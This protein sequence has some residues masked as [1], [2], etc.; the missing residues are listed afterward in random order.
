MHIE[1]IPGHPTKLGAQ[2]VWRVCE[3]IADGTRADTP[4]GCSERTL[5]ACQHHGVADALGL[6]QAQVA[7]A[8]LYYGRTDQPLTAARTTALP[9]AVHRFC[10]HVRCVY[11]DGSVLVCATHPVSEFVIDPTSAVSILA[12]Q[13]WLRAEDAPLHAAFVLG[14][15]RECDR[16]NQV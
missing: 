10:D 3:Q 9:T 7:L 12:Y 15:L 14:L 1:Q 16:R 6:T 5:E 11:E 13:N 2:W 8:L 4:R